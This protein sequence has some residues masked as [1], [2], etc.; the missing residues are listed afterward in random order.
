M[1]KR[2]FLGHTFSV[3]SSKRFRLIPKIQLIDPLF[4]TFVFSWLGAH[5]WIRKTTEVEKRNLLRGKG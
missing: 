2:F 5:G 1:N 3:S 4:N